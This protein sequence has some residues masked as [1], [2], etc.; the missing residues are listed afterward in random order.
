MSFFNFLSK[1]CQLGRW[2]QNSSSIPVIIPTRNIQSQKQPAQVPIIFAITIT[3]E[4]G[5]FC[6][7]NSGPNFDGNARRILILVEFRKNSKAIWF[8]SG[9]NSFLRILILKNSA[10]ILE[11][12]LQQTNS[13][14]DGIKSTSTKGQFISK[15]DWCAIDS[16]KKRTDEFDLFAVKS[17]KAKKTNSSVRFL[18]ESMARQSAFE[19]N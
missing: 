12:F 4:A 3:G 5:C 1:L 2:H 8:F 11:K 14:K 18:G 19:I 6:E 9:R 10:I 17:K 13:A 16:P 7:W 15:A